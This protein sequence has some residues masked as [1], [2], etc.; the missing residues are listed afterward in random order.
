MKNNKTKVE[1]RGVEPRSEITFPGTSTHIVRF[2]ISFR[3]HHQTGYS[4]T[5]PL[6]FRFA[7][8]EAR[9]GYRN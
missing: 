6:K 3:N 7:Y 8:T 9:L 4:E 1:V 2:L 5:I